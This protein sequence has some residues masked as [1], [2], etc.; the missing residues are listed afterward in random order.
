M[1][2]L[3][4]IPHAIKNPEWGIIF[5]YAILKTFARADINGIHNFPLCPMIAAE[6]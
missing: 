1:L 5:R 6:P 4:E 2:L 3:H